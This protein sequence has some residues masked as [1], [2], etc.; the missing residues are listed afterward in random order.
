M[1]FSFQA[2]DFETVKLYMMVEFHTIGKK[3][4]NEHSKIKK[5]D[6]PFIHDNFLLEN[7]YAEESCIIIFQN[8]PII[9]YQSLTTVYVTMYLKT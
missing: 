7:K 6:A 4:T 1:F 3:P 5:N 2:S 9:D 8:Q